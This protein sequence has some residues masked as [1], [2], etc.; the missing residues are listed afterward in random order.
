MN[1][2]GTSKKISYVECSDSEDEENMI[3]LV[4][5]VKGRKTISCPFSKKGTRNIRFNITKAAKIFDLLL[6]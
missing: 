5:W 1:Q 4:K 6:Q 2:E 3:W